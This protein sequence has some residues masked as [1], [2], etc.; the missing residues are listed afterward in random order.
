MGTKQTNFAICDCLIMC[1]EARPVADSK[2][3]LIMS[4]SERFKSL[5][6]GFTALKMHLIFCVLLDTIKLHTF[7]FAYLL[8]Q[9]TFGL[10][11]GYLGRGKDPS[12]VAPSAF[13]SSSL[14]KSTTVSSVAGGSRFF[15]LLASGCCCW[16]ICASAAVW[17]P[18]DFRGGEGEAGG[19][20]FA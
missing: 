5:L 12:P 8:N 16:T 10:F 14:S 1:L 2:T 7:C 4:H 6:E 15:H 18:G 9:Q 13:H 19:G 20:G 3:S 17:L 11:G